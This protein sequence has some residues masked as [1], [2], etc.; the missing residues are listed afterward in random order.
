M[1][2]LVCQIMLHK[3]I[4]LYGLIITAIMLIG[5]V[6]RLILIGLGWPLTNSDEGTMGIM[7]LHIAY[8]GQHPIFFYG[9]NYMGS[10]EAFLAAGIFHLIGPSLFALRLGTVLMFALFLVSFYLL[11]RLLFSRTWAFVSLWL[12]SLGSAYVMAQELRAIGG[13][14]ET[15]LFGTLLFLCSSWLVLTYQRKNPTGRSLK[16]WL[17]YLSWGLVAGL[18]LWSDPLIAP[19][20][21]A[22]GLLL[23]LV[24]WH[25]LLKLVPLICLLIGLLIGA[26]PLIYYN[27]HAAPG[28]NSLEILNVLRGTGRGIYHLSAIVKELHSSTMVSIPM[29]T[30]EPFCPVSELTFI[31]PSSS[32]TFA[33]SLA[34]DGWS[35]TYLAL[36]SISVVITAY[37]LWLAWQ[38][39]K[40]IEAGSALQ[41]ELR[42]QLARLFLLVSAIMTLG[43]YV[44]SEAPLTGAG[45]HGRY[46]ICLLTATPIIFWP[47]W[48]GIQRFRKQARFSDCALQVLC[49]CILLSFCVLSLIGSVLTFTQ[50]PAA[51]AMNQSDAGLIQELAH[52]HVKSIYGSYWTCDKIAFESSEKVVCA[53]ITAQLQVDVFGYDRYFPYVAAVEADH[54][55]AY[56]FSTDPEQFPGPVNSPYIALINP[57][58]RISSLPD[59]FGANFTRIVISNY[60]IYLPK[61]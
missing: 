49:A 45:I 13:Y 44:F 33:C 7:A 59:H 28:Q 47:L 61:I 57:D 42:Q 10:W 60:I 16:R 24:C 14:A 58:A 23:L 4:S 32:Q 30:G 41:S 21:F 51:V 2:M 22:S 52:L 39:R 31:G 55:A 43:F 35:L 15:L 17:V 40:L 1:L 9:Q 25:E 6:L 8:Q 18:G 27:L 46:L 54:R 19:M 48:L 5:T 20:I 36:L 11:T 53:L 56:V 12:V 38:K 37:S 3:K 26:E 50:V 29:M 34:H